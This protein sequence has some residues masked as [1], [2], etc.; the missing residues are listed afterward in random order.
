MFDAML[1]KIWIF[2]TPRSGAG[3]TKWLILLMQVGSRFGQ[4]LTSICRSGA[5]LDKATCPSGIFFQVWVRCVSMK[6]G[7]RIRPM[8]NSRY[9]SNQLVSNFKLFVLQIFSYVLTPISWP[10]HS[11]NRNGLGWGRNM[12]L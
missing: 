9:S 4:E 3:R 2:W 5:L 11:L 8:A 7:V 6:S 1:D 10:L 12:T